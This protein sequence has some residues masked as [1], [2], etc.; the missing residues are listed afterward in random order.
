MQVSSARNA[1][2]SALKDD[3]EAVAIRLTNTMGLASPSTFTVTIDGETVSIPDRVY[4]DEVTTRAGYSALHL[5]V[6]DCLQ[7]RHHSG[8]VRERALRR[9]LDLNTSWSA[10]FT[11]QLISEYVVEILE[12]I[13]ANWGQIDERMV[14]RFLAENP[15]FHA[16]VKQRV[17]SYW[18]TY[19][20]R[21]SRESYVG[22]KLLKRLERLTVDVARDN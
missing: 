8:F 6:L 12:I 10:P 11:V 20:R 18:N 19:Y 3:A 13:E 14:A 22:F 16:L 5:S 9:I 4:F 2:P 15:R 17:I 21:L 1:F 7:T